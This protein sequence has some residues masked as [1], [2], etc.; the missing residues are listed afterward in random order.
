MKVP[1][2]AGALTDRAPPGPKAVDPRL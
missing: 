1:D 2:R